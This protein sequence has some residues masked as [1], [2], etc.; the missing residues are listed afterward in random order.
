MRIKQLLIMHPEVIV[1]INK[2]IDYIEQNLSEEHRLEK[3]AEIGNLLKYHFHRTFQ[4]IVKE[5]PNEYLTRKRLEKVALRLIYGAN[6]TISD[7][8]F[9]YGFRNQSSFS[10]TFK[11]FYGFN[12]SKLKKGIYNHHFLENSKI[13]INSNSFPKYLCDVAKIKDWMKTQASI[14][15]EHL[16]EMDLVYC[17]HWGS[18]NTIHIAYEK[19]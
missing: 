9:K 5:S 14:G 10:R 6:M 13:G 8:S 7:V 4:L 12:A 16:S 2:V 1:K 3:L 19:Y 11:K 17:R 15:I 18:V